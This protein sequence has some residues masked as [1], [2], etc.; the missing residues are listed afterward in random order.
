MIL[1]KDMCNIAKTFVAYILN[2]VLMNIKIKKIHHRILL[3]LIILIPVNQIILNYLFKSRIFTPVAEN[4]NFLI[5]PTLAANLMS[6]TVFSLLIFVLGKHNLASIGFSKAKLKIAALLVFCIWLFSQTI[7]IVWSY[8]S[9]GEVV[10]VDQINILIGSF[11]GQAFGNAAFEELIYRGILFLQFFLLF[12]TKTTKQK[13]I[14]FSVIASQI[15]FAVIHI[16]N[17]LLIHSVDSLALDLL[18]LFAAGVVLTVI[19]IRTENIVFLTGIHALINQ[20]FNLTKTS[21]PA[22][23]IIYLLV[24]LTAI[25]WRKI[26]AWKIFENL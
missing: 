13:S 24:I 23:I 14:L 19:F 6:L 4:T 8:L 21:F 7:T 25:F 15:I 18:G 1:K 12:N 10:F 20:P 11:L 17:R 26:N 9:C 16:P 3:L 5:Q 22:E 2:T